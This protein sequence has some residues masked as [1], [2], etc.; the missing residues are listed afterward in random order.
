MCVCVC[1]CVV[2]TLPGISGISESLVSSMA[3]KTRSYIR[4][5]KNK[6]EPGMVVHT[7]NPSTWRLEQEDWELKDSLGYIARPCLRKKKAGNKQNPK[8]VLFL[9]CSLGL[10]VW[11]ILTP[12]LGMLE[13]QSLL[14]DWGLL[15]SVRAS[16]V[17]PCQITWESKQCPTFPGKLS[18]P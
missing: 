15:S 13:A 18:I 3:R 8:H 12:W 1:V 14:R 10:G 4:M 6:H 5:L 11:I 17:H 9:W 7:Y 2:H 16:L